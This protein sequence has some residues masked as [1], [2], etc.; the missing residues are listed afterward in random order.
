MAWAGNSQIDMG[1]SSALQEAQRHQLDLIFVTDGDQTPHRR[2]QRLGTL[3]GQRGQARG[4][5]VGVGG[6]QPRPVPR[7]DAQDRIVGYWEPEEAQR[8]GFNPNMVVQAGGLNFSYGDADAGSQ[9]HLSALR[10]PELNDMARAAGLRYLHLSDPDGL[11]TQAL[12]T[13]LAVLA[14]AP[15]DLRFVFGLGAMLLLLGGWM[16]REQAS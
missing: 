8:Q 15:R 14:D 13:E 9:E 7:L 16:G 3:Q 11:R 10:E 5:V 1:L 6:A 4:W 12:D 2:A